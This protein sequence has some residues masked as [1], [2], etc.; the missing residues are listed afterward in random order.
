[1]NKII[2][3]ISGALQLVLM[4]PIKLPAKALSIIKYL[5]LGLGIL[6]KVTEEESDGS[7]EVN[8]L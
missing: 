2:K 6:E 5:A 8:K 3:K 4:A 1:M 7:D